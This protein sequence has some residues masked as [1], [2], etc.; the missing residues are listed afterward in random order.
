M[1][2]SQHHDQSFT[3]DTVD[4]HIEQLLHQ[5]DQRQS[6]TKT[7]VRVIRDLHTLYEEDAE[8]LARVRERFVSS[9]TETDHVQEPTILQQDEARRFHPTEQPFSSQSA[10]RQRLS[11]L[12]AGL[13]AAFIISSMLT[14]FT[15]VRHPATQGASLGQQQTPSGLYIGSGD[16]VYRIDQR[17][18]KVLWHYQL[19]DDHK[20][21]FGSHPPIVVILN[22]GPDNTIYAI[23]ESTVYAIDAT[24]GILHWSNTLFK[25]VLSGSK[26]IVSGNRVYV[27]VNDSVYALSTT[28]GELLATYSVGTTVEPKQ[29]TPVT[30]IGR[31]V[32][33]NA[34]NY[35]EVVQNAIL[36]TV[37]DNIL[38]ITKRADLYAL[39]LPSGK[40]LWHRQVDQGQQLST[41]HVVDGQIYVASYS[42]T[43]SKV[44][45]YLYAFN[46]QTGVTVWQPMKI[47][48]GWVYDIVVD[49]GVIYGS[50]VEK[51]V[52]AYD[53]RTGKALWSKGAN[54]AGT[55]APQV[56][57]GTVY[58]TM[59]SSSSASNANVPY[60][61]FPMMLVALDAKSGSIKWIHPGDVQ[62]KA[63][64][65]TTVQN[66]VIYV[67]ESRSGTYAL[68]DNG[69]TILWSNQLGDKATGLIVVVVP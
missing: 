34:G 46:A 15:F 45:D 42:H 65:F 54:V 68:K 51:R 44:A 26:P 24:R 55:A 25:E 9:I 41:P 4:E 16:M 7:N 67:H 40:Q 17:S 33:Y 50:V 27:T 52:F 10:S 66:G 58:I 61:G 62:G 37:H 21:N 6:Q 47:T 8:L 28:D 53:A 35:A 38:Y 18:G 23:S 31:A 11:L 13:V 43:Q 48:D 32:G 2:K 3:P 59:F 19:Q 29:L 14:V 22:T 60:V 30:M 12:A 39:S 64:V 63:G 49:H 36:T 5:Q 1:G 56:D 57:G 69:K 20:A